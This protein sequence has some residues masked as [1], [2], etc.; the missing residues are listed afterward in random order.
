MEIERDVS[1]RH[2]LKKLKKKGG[3]NRY[4]YIYISTKQET[5]YDDDDETNE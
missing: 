1:R 3:K 5:D 2:W 4:I